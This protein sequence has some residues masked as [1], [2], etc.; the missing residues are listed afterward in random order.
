MVT[1]PTGGGASLPHPPNRDDAATTSSK[2]PVPNP[3]GEV[4]G[5]APLEAALHDLAAHDSVVQLTKIH[6]VHVGTPTP[7][8]LT[9]QTG[10]QE[11]ED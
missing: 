1:T 7:L 8:L 2:I 3:F 10:S 4:A 5:A 9:A 6:R 11:H